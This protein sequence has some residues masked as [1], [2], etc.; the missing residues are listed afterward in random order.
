MI[1]FADGF[2]PDGEKVL[3]LNQTP[4]IIM[5]ATTHATTA[6]QLI[7]PKS[8]SASLGIDIGTRR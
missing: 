2:P 6:N 5:L 8:I 3:G 4:P 1:G 7:E